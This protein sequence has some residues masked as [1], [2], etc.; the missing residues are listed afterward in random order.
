MG[1][2][3]SVIVEERAPGRKPKLVLPISQ[4]ELNSAGYHVQILEVSNEQ[5]AGVRPQPG[6]R[7]V[8]KFR[9]YTVDG[10]CF[11]QGDA[12]T[13]VVGKKTTIKAWD[14][15][16]REIPVGAR[17]QVS[18]APSHGYGDQ[19]APFIPPGSTLLF[20]M[21]LKSCSSPGR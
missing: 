13:F 11:G 7:V 5:S 15:A 3:S 14:L 19:P 8:V 9:G 18:V 12:F 2:N 1:C 21:T 16:I 4:E 20:D 6:D 10:I 17:A